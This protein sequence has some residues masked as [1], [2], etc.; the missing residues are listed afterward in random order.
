MSTESFC[1]KSV[2]GIVNSKIE[3]SDLIVFKK[4]PTTSGY[5]TPVS[6]IPPIEDTAGDSPVISSSP[7]FQQLNWP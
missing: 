2:K 6:D 3:R 1:P 5:Q 7:M 4:C